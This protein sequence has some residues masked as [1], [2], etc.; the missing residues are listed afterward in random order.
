MLIINFLGHYT[1]RKSPRAIEICLI[2]RQWPGNFLVTIHIRLLLTLEIDHMT[3]AQIS[4][5]R[6]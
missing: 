1:A 6:Y 5:L 4:L 3:I 2:Y